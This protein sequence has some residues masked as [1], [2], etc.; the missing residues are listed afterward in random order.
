LSAQLFLVVIVVALGFQSPDIDSRILV[1]ISRYR[2]LTRDFRSGSA[3]ISAGSTTS[4]ENNIVDSASP[5]PY[6]RIAAKYCLSRI[7][8]LAMPTRWRSFITELS[9]A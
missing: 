9:N 4:S 6:G 2:A 5:D 3:S 1:A 7:T 8:T